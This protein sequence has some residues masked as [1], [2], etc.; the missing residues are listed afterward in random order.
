MRQQQASARRATN[1]KDAVNSKHVSLGGDGE[2]WRV[3]LF[4]GQL[5]K[6]THVVFAVYFQSV[7]LLPY[8]WKM[9]DAQL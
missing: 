7:D 4:Q 2:R 5:T 3:V 6:S 1:I 9:Q 8:V